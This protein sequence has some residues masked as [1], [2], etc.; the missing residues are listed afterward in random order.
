MI[1]GKVYWTIPK[2]KM[3]NL[4][5]NLEEEDIV[6]QLYYTSLLN[7]I[8]QVR[9]QTPIT[10]YYVAKDLILK[11][12]NFIIEHEYDVEH[13]S[14]QLVGYFEA[15]NNKKAEKVINYIT[16]NDNYLSD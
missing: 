6:N 7:F 5:L 3:K 16:S 14:Y 12:F 11:N 9:Q 8:S 1:F 10:N 2:N 4:I 13:I 15:K